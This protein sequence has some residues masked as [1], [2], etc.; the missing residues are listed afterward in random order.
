MWPPTPLKRIALL[1]AVAPM[2]ISACTHGPKMLTVVDNGHSYPAG[3]IINCHSGTPTTFE[4]LM[5]DVQK[6]QVVYV[7]E[8]HTD[9]HHHEIQLQIIKAL[10]QQSGSSVI[11]GME[12]FAAVYQPVLNDWSNGKLNQ[13][14]F[15]E[16]VH[17]YANWRYDYALYEAILAHIKSQQTPLVGLNLP[18]HIPKKI[19]VGGIDNLLPEDRR[20]LPEQIDTSNADHRAYV[21]DVFTH[22]K[23][24][25][26]TKFDYFY[27]AQCVWEDTMAE[28]I[29]HH[30]DQDPMVVLLGGGHI[31]R[32]FGV[33]DRAHTR[34]L[35]PFRTIYL[36][37]AG[38]S[39]E[40]AWADYIWVTPK[41]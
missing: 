13:T 31:R 28:N 40:L 34:T 2:L 8:R 6:V 20:H 35:A 27:E 24:L 16:R 10:Q 41:D 23:F 18:F 36:A 14:Q 21:E 5:A 7:G 1:V 30:L 22:H 37:S 9:A 29:A 15:L 19:R 25:S 12:M 38:D 4:M 11:V 33:P 32:H 26:Q 3:T 39:V 17:W